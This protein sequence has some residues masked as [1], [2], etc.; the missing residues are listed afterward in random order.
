MSVPHLLSTL[1][2]PVEDITTLL[3]DAASVL[4]PTGLHSVV[5]QTLAGKRIVLAFFEPSTR[6]RLSFETAAKRLG[7]STIFVQTSGSSVE[8]G[9]TMR[10][11]IRTIEAMGF[12]AIIMR[13]AQNGIM[14]EIASYSKMSVINAGEGS[15]SHPTQAL[16][17]AS[18][19]REALGS[20]QGKKIAIVGD[21]RHSRVAQSTSDVLVRLGAEVAYCSPDTFA[22][23]DQRLLLLNRLDSIDEAIG[24]ADVVYLLR[25]QWER[26]D[27]PHEFDVAAYRQMYSYTEARALANP[28]VLV[29]H[30]GPVNVGVEIDENV[31]ELAQCKIHQQ[32]THGVAVRMA[33]LKRLLTT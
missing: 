26:I 23:I 18:T 8:K 31:L 5:P 1:D 22:P 32:V 2:L 17:D 33:V 11:T 15:L 3:D 28:A 9:E 16:L 13:H 7:A 30:P 21:L 6:T 25:I 29:M 4:S 27:G 20:V 14:H 10:E 24:W 12:D 19:I